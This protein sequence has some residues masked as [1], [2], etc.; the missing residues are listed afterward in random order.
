MHCNLF[1][2]LIRPRTDPSEA[3]A[4]CRYPE[5]RGKTIFYKFVKRSSRSPFAASSTTRAHVLLFGG[6]QKRIRSIFKRSSMIFKRSLKIRQLE[7]L[8]KWT[9]F[10]ENITVSSICPRLILRL[11]RFEIFAVY[12]PFAADF[13]RILSYLEVRAVRS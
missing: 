6:Q 12:G 1:D 4:D 3:S 13:C 8:L 7:R 9:V 2:I 10:H 5:N 11:V